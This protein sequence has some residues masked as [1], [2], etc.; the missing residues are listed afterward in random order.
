MK[1]TDCIFYGFTGIINPLG[2]LGEQ[3]KRL[4]ITCLEHDL[5]AFRTFFQH[6]AVY[7]AD[8]SIKIVIYCLSVYLVTLPS[9]LL[10]ILVRKESNDLKAVPSPH[11]PSRS[12][13]A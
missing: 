11:N 12:M 5:Q 13:K 4:L 9:P 1:A 2:M 7:Y 3:S 6:P 10:V 8:N